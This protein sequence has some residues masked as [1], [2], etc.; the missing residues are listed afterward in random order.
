MYQ[1]PPIVIRHSVHVFFF[2]SV[3]ESQV[4][5]LSHLSDPYIEKSVYLETRNSS[6][7]TGNNLIVEEKPFLTLTY[8]CTHTYLTVYYS[9][10]AVKPH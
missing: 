7:K 5:L 1:N 9:L 6:Q 4:I 8:M 10:S 2:L 3:L